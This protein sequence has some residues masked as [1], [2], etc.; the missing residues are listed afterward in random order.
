MSSE[1]VAV[2]VQSI[3]R[4]ICFSVASTLMYHVNCRWWETVALPADV[5]AVDE[6]QFRDQMKE[7]ASEV[8]Y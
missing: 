2:L 4:H 3:A 5:D 6:R 1:L 8:G 7:I